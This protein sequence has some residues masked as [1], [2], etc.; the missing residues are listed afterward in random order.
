MSNTFS[1][2]ILS[3]AVAGALLVGAGGISTAKADLEFNV[4]VFSDYILWGTTA[5]NNNA[6]VQGGV[7][8]A[9]DSGIYVGTWISTLD[10]DD[11][12][13]VDL[14]AGYEFSAGDLD[15]DLGLVYYYYTADSDANYADIYASVGFGPVY[16]GVNYAA[17][18]K[19][20][21]YEGSIVYTIGGGF[22]VMPT[23]SLDGEVGYTKQKAILDTGEDFSWTF[24]SLSLTKSTD[25]GDISVTYAQTNESDIDE[26][27][28]VGYSL[29]F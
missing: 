18:A 3:S 20:S 26:L 8:Y 23:I 16:A 5:S 4:G 27:F 17:Y 28:V 2:K 24:W 12:Q 21:D 25:M 10:A 11:G 13:E 9:D 19:D 6:V 29:S 1:K 7:D 14:Y 22:E 15:F